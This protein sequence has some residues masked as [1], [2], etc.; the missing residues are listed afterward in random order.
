MLTN[1][2]K[3][4]ADAYLLGGDPHEAFRKAGYR[5]KNVQAAARRLLAAP[6]VKQYLEEKSVVDRERQVAEPTEILQY[7]T[8]VLRGEHGSDRE[9][10][11]AAELLGKRHGLFS[12]TLTDRAAAVII[13]D[14]LNG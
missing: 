7:L 9:R 8:A 12:D 2:Q 6:A 1:R 4:F 13:V 14:D 3:Q 11:R 10:L 5:E